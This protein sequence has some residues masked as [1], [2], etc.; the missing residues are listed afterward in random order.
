MGPLH[1]TPASSLPLTWAF[2]GCCLTQA[3]LE[4]ILFI[5]PISLLSQSISRIWGILLSILT[6]AVCVCL[7]ASVRGVA[8]ALG[9][10][11]F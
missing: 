11:I 2:P 9:L 5:L 4:M 1:E 6:C 10:F 3:A 7:P 8:H